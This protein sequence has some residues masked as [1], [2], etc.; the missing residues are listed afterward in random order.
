MIVVSFTNSEGLEVEW[1]NVYF[2]FFS[3][4]FWIGMMRSM[5]HIIWK[6]DI[7]EIHDTAVER[8]LSIMG[9]TLFEK[10][11]GVIVTCSSGITK[12]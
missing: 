8:T 2:I 10:V 7:F 1:C 4:L 6:M 5:Q 11:N 3:P 9:I 12:R